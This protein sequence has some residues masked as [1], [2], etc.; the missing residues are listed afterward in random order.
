M[1]T[2]EHFPAQVGHNDLANRV[3]SVQRFLVIYWRGPLSS[4]GCRLVSQ[5]GRTVREYEG[6]DGEG[7]RQKCHHYSP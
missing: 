4:M 7:D 3:G 1:V 6:E 5:S 2:G